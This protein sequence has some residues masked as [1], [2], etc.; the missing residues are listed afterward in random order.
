MCGIAGFTGKGNRPVL[1][2]MI[3]ALRHRGPDNLGF[4]ECDGVSMAHSRL[5]ILDMSPAGHQPM[6][7]DQGDVFLSYNGEIYNFRQLREELQKKGYKFAS[8]TD[9]EVIIYLYKEYGEECLKMLNGMFALAIY[10]KRNGKIILA[11]DRMGEKP[12]Y[13]SFKNGELVFASEIGAMLVHP[14]ISK[15]LDTLAVYQ[16]FAFDYVPQPRT[17]F[18]DIS[19]LENGQMLVWENGRIRS[20]KFYELKIKEDI[21]VGEEKA[22]EKLAGLLEDSVKARLVSDA[23]LGVFLSGGIDSS[24]V[25]YF[26]KKHK[27]DLKTFSIGFREKT[28]DES[29]YIKMAVKAV[30]SNHYHKEF[31]P[32]EMTDF[33]P[34]IFAKLDEP[35]GDPSLLPTFL[36][37]R[38]AREQVTVALGGDGGDELFMGYPNYKFQKVLHLTGLRK[39]KINDFFAKHLL[40]IFPASSKNMAFPFMA[41]RAIMSGRF[42]AHLRDFAAVG[43]YHRLLKEL[44][45]FGRDAEKE[46][47]AFADEYLNDHK[48]S[49]YMA[50]VVLLFQKYYL[51][52]NILFKADRASMYSSLEE[53]SPFLDCRLVDFANSLPHNLKLKGINSK[54]VF[55]KAMEGKLPAA[56]IHRKKKGFGVPLA[57]WLRNELKDFMLETL[58]ESNIKE[59]G[60]INFDVVRRLINDHLSGKMDNKKILWNLVIF[61]RWFKNNLISP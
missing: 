11:R 28:F 22:A 45:L 30:G 14:T 51:S 41:Q 52:D 16:F 53:R 58:S 21:T 47:F 24:A 7:C 37:S 34:E 2:K 54:H 20:D 46:L 15:D 23:P 13:W 1:E 39:I 48:D 31:S 35:F 55:K 33:L 19:K 56:I 36:L 18:K 9:T 10:D 25:A 6:K 4:Y 3:A 5:S 26:A 8:G 38:F 50:K 32:K 42:P 60:F 61:T 27:S 44:F 40:K 43:G 12:L 17:V 57:A 49:D 29:G 59:T